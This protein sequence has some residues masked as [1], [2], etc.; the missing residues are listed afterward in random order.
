MTEPMN[1]AELE[2]AFAFQRQQL[3]QQAIVAVTAAASRHGLTWRD[4]VVMT[5][6]K[7]QTRD[8]QTYGL[9]AVIVRAKARIGAR[10]RDIWRLTNYS[11]S[12]AVQIGLQ[13]AG[14]TIKNGT[15]IAGPGA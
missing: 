9:N 8:R 10:V 13:R 14:Y 5:G 6:G 1:L 7:W 15:I 2:A 12:G 11:N 3:R 4:V